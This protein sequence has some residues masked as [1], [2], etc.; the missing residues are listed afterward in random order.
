MCPQYCCPYPVRVQAAL[1]SVGRIFG[2]SHL[3]ACEMVWKVHWRPSLFEGR[4]SIIP[5][6]LRLRRGRCRSISFRIPRCMCVCSSH[7]SDQKYDRVIGCI[8]VAIFAS[9]ARCS[10]YAHRWIG[11][12]HR[13]DL[14]L[15]VPARAYSR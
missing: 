13:F 7:R 4:P 15:M 11:M 2:A 5:L 14:K 1:Q 6:T 3:H 9:H 12:V 10:L 8:M